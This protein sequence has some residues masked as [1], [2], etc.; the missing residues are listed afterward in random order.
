M[1][2]TVFSKCILPNELINAQRMVKI[3]IKQLLGH[4]GFLMLRDGTLEIKGKKPEFNLN[5]VKAI[6]LDM[7]SAYTFE[8]KFMKPDFFTSFSFVEGLMSAQ[9]MSQKGVQIHCLNNRPV[10][11]L[12]S[13]TS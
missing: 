1:K 13:G 3:K 9:Q 4:V 7:E 6:A 12:M 10:Y 11:N 8:D 2:G 5:A